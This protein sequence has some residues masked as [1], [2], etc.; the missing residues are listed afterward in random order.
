MLKIGMYNPRQIY[1]TSL[2]CPP[3]S[4]W[5]GEGDG[6]PGEAPEDRPESADT[7]EEHGEP[8]QQT[9]DHVAKSATAS[10]HRLPGGGCDAGGAGGAG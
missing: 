5:N 3:L 4:G 1:C 6:E 2:W 8:E 9:G 10:R 7:C